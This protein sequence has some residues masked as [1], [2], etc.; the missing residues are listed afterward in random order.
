M[1]VVELTY[2]VRCLM[3]VYIMPTFD[4]GRTFTDV[5]KKLTNIKITMCDYGTLLCFFRKAMLYPIELG[6]QL[7]YPVQLL[8]LI[9]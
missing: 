4:V 1:V 6:C 9:T 2:L 7:L 5:G 3:Q 8:R